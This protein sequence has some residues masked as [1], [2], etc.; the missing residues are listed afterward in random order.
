MTF[1]DLPY[2]YRKFSEEK[3]WEEDQAVAYYQQA[4]EFR[5]YMEETICKEFIYHAISGREPVRP[6]LLMDSVLGYLR[7]H[8][9]NIS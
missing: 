7:G 1:D 2:K 9:V 6:A 4:K 5:E 3:E 8:G